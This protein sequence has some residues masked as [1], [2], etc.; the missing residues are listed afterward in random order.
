[1]HKKTSIAGLIF[2][3]LLVVSLLYVAVLFYS[4]LELFSAIDTAQR[5]GEQLTNIRP[6]FDH[7]LGIDLFAIIILLTLFLLPAAFLLVRMVIRPIHRLERAFAAMTQGNFDVSLKPEGVS[8]LQSIGEG[9]NTAIAAVQTKTEELAQLNAQLSRDY[10]QA[11]KIND[12][13]DDRELV[14]IKLKE[15]IARLKKE[16][17]PRI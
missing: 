9:F 8:E 4:Y 16:L 17:P 12:I 7:I 13:T 1:M 15:E 3:L 10:G 2:S 5:I 6:I 11:K 14:M